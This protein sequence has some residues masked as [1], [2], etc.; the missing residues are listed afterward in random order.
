[1]QDLGEP[2]AV[3]H[4]VRPEREV[5]QPLDSVAVELVDEGIGAVLTIRV[6]TC[7]SS[8]HGCS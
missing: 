7:K 1:V 3:V 8:V 6:V 2:R 5:L 4:P